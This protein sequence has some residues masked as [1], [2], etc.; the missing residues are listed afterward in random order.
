MRQEFVRRGNPVDTGG[1]SYGS[2]SI[3][4]TWEYYGSSTVEE[5]RKDVAH[6]RM[7]AES[8]EGHS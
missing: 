3:G 7:P 5:V 1:R 2:L 6:G 4:S 8:R